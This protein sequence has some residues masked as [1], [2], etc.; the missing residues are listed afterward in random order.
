MERVV[1]TGGIPGVS[2]LPLEAPGG[3]GTLAW[4]RRPLRTRWKGRGAFCTMEKP[5][6][7][8]WPRWLGGLRST[9]EE[10]FPQAKAEPLAPWLG[11]G[12]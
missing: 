1:Q 2:G 8:G 11:L 5:E 10:P 3:L 4:S 7:R 9:E 12:H 6:G